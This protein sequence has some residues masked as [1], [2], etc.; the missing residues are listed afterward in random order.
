MTVRPPGAIWPGFAVAER[1]SV[2]PDPAV[3]SAEVK[4]RNPVPDP[5]IADI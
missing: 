5:E 4:L 1:I 3:A 2:R